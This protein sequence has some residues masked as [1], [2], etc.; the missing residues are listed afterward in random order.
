MPPNTQMLEAS[1]TRRAVAPLVV[2]DDDV[3]ASVSV[4]FGS[5]PLRT[6]VL[7]PFT[8]PMCTRLLFTF[9]PLPMT[10]S[11]YVELVLS[12]HPQALYC[13][14]RHVTGKVS[15]WFGASVLLVALW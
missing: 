13:W 1:R 3:S 6:I 10:E 4:P 5:V 8:G 15:F 14:Q 11:R 7:V 12:S 9:V 2:G